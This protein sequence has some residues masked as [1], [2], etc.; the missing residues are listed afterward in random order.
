MGTIRVGQKNPCFYEAGNVTVSVPIG[1]EVVT[2]EQLEKKYSDEE[3]QEV[4]RGIMALPTDEIV[5]KLR[6]KGFNDVAD[7]VEQQMKEQEQQLQEK[8]RREVRL[9]EILAMDEGDQLPLLLEEGYDEEARILSEKFAVEQEDSNVSDEHGDCDGSQHA[10]CA[11]ADGEKEPKGE[12]FP[13]ST[14]DAFVEKKPV[15]KE[16]K[17][18]AASKKGE[19]RRKKS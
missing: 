9:K 1:Q 7:Y 3:V 16:S 4:I 19:G 17:A 15:K 2:V 8:V 14:A 10:V 13:S 12:G 6:E 18:K 5:P 11:D